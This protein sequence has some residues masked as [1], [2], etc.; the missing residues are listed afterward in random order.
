MWCFCRLGESSA[1]KRKDILTPA[2]TW[3]DP[4]DIKLSETSQ[5]QGADVVGF[6]S[7]EV[8]RGLKFRQKVGGRQ[9]LGVGELEF[10]V[11]KE[12]KFQRWTVG[13]DAQQCECS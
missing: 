6:H 13:M 2:M 9:D 7:H 12:R 5:S 11:G 4:E 3:M 1:L 10:Q 8:P